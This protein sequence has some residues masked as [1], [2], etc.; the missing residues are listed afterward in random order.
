MSKYRKGDRVTLTGT[1]E[2]VLDEKVRVQLTD[3]FSDV[4]VSAD[5]VS[6]ERA[7]FH[8]GDEVDVAGHYWEVLAVANDHL[9]CVD[10]AGDYATIQA[11]CATRLLPKE[12]LDEV[13]A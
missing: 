8:V 10:T 4:F 11:K 3:S 13:A 2:Y 5:A 12:N 6:M 1:V 9:W 7:N